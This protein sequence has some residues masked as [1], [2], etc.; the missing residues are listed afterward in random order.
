M[1]EDKKTDKFRRACKPAIQQKLELEDPRTLFQMQVIAQRVDEIYWKYNPV[2]NKFPSGG[3]RP[4]YKNPDAMELDLV[5]EEDEQNS[6]GEAEQDDE[7][8]LNVLR[9]RPRLSKRNPKKSFHKKSINSNMNYKERVRCLEKGLCFK[10]KKSGHRIR[11][12]PQ[13]RTLKGKAQ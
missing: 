10:C 7:E 4:I 11:D 1:S 9:G 5:A 3:R 13:W 12:C 2:Q 6:D 8:H